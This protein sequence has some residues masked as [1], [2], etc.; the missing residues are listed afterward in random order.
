MQRWHRA[1]LAQRAAQSDLQ[2]LREWD[3]LYAEVKRTCESMRSAQD[4]AVRREAAAVRIQCAAR[5]RLGRRA[6]LDLAV[7]RLQCAARQKLSR[8]ALENAYWSY[9]YG[10]LNEESAAR[11]QRW[12]RRLGAQ[13][14]A[15]AEL[16]LLR[17]YDLLIAHV[18]VARKLRV[19]AAT[20][21][22]RGY[23]RHHRDTW[24]AGMRGLLATTRLADEDNPF[25]E[26]FAGAEEHRK[27]VE[28]AFG[29]DGKLKQFG[30]ISRGAMARALPS[31]LATMFNTLR[32]VDAVNGLLQRRVVEVTERRPKEEASSAETGAAT[33]A[34]TSPAASATSGAAAAA[35]TGPEE[36]VLLAAQYEDLM[37][38]GDKALQARFGGCT[39]YLKA[40]KRFGLLHYRGQMLHEG[41]SKRAVLESSS[42]GKTRIE[43]LE[44]ALAR[45]GR[46]VPAVLDEEGHLN[47]FGRE[48]ARAKLAKLIFATRMHA[49]A[50]PTLD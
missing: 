46:I 30:H 41:T 4:L 35:A 33:S 37:A 38:W 42:V 11:L 9:A 50:P 18:K 26:G 8:K 2:D 48:A 10:L 22:Q 20:V 16:E 12:W 13:R 3:A 32:F 24:L 28:A 21:L 34:V 29:K 5:R 23:R 27:R 44:T 40:A 36:T 39:Q 49:E 25:S 6:L 17:G 45:P 19:A 15:K 43:L 31:Q 47:P 14:A 1:R 7:T